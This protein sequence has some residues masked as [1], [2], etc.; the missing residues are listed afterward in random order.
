[1]PKKSERSE[2]QGKPDLAPYSSTANIAVA[3]NKAVADTAM[4]VKD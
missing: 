2:K 1:L 4:G 3:V